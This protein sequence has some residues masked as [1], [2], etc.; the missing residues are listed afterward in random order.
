MND[1]EL[2]DMF[3]FGYTGESL[4]GEERIG[5]LGFGFKSDSM[6]LGSDVIVLTISAKT[7]CIGL[8][9]KD[10]TDVDLS[11]SIATC[12]KDKKEFIFGDTI[13]SQ[14]I[15]STAGKIIREFENMQSSEYHHGTGTRI[16]IYNLMEG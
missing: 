12:D 10:N 6:K 16:I 11:V 15:F 7:W 5:Q 1:K 9:D 4:L 8:Y 13:K 14:S 3:S 2:L